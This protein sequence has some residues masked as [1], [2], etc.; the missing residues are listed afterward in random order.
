MSRLGL[1][2]L[3]QAMK[4]GGAELDQ[5]Q[6]RARQRLAPLPSVLCVG[7]TAGFYDHGLRSGRSCWDGLDT[8]C[9]NNELEAQAKGF[10]W[11]LGWGLGMTQVLHL[12]FPGR[13]YSAS[14]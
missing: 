9:V 4:N 3:L 10:S 12:L 1:P 11:L 6:V 14:V 13:T 8:L 7:D 5:M 2:F